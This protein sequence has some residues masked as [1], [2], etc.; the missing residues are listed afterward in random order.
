M[1]LGVGRGFDRPD[2]ACQVERV[3]HGWVVGITLLWRGW[4]Q[5]SWRIALLGN[6][7]VIGVAVLVAGWWYWRN[8]ALYGDLS[9]T[10]PIL[11]SD[12]PAPLP[13]RPGALGR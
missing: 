8:F 12:G 9:G 13:A 6:G 4:Q 5:G 7:V 2:G 10:Q 11:L 1:A 3:R